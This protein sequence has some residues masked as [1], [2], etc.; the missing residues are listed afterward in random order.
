MSNRNVLAEQEDKLACFTG[1]P[2]GLTQ[3]E[4]CREQWLVQKACM[5]LARILHPRIHELR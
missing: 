4:G 5:A 1:R 2:K 3:K